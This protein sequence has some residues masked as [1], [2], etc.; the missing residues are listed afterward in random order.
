MKL[1]VLIASVLLA[2]PVAQA[3]SD[4]PCGEVLRIGLRDSIQTVYQGSSRGAV[5]DFLCSADSNYALASM[6]SGASVPIPQLGGIVSGNFDAQKVDEWRHSSCA[7]RSESF[8]EEVASKFLSST[9]SRYTPDAINAWQACRTASSNDGN[10]SP[11]IGSVA[12]YDGTDFTLRI[13]YRP[14]TSAVRIEK[15][16][17]KNVK[18][19]WSP[20]ANDIFELDRSVIC[21][22]A[23]ASGRAS[24]D[25]SFKNA[26]PMKSVILPA[27]SPKIK[28][29]SELDNCVGTVIACQNVGD[30]KDGV[31]AL[32]YNVSGRY[33]VTFGGWNNVECDRTGNGWHQAGGSCGVGTGNGY[34][35]CGSVRVIPD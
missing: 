25:L 12:D 7:T 27:R 13:R 1:R 34:K 20:N 8:S 4:D 28:S 2:A 14:L 10:P 15:L 35:R 3:Q 29:C 6:D 31:T 17:L 22:R 19:D 5:Y 16:T 26:Q 11:A 24:I 30:D 18:C 21:S 23:D 33:A 32:N 9:L